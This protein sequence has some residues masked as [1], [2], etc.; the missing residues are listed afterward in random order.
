MSIIQNRIVIMFII[1]AIGFICAKTGL[2]DG[3]GNKKLSKLT[4]WLVNPLLMFMSYQSEYSS[5]VAKNLLLTLLCSAAVFALHI[6]AASLLIPRKNKE[7]AIERM[8]V[9]FSNCGFIGIP[10]VQGVY[11]SEGVIYVTM[12][13]TVFNILIWTYGVFMMKGSRPDSLKGCLKNL[14]T[15]AIISVISGLVFYFCRISLPHIISEPLNAVGSMNTPMAMLVAGATL[16][17]TNFAKCL[18]K[19]RIYLLCAVKLLIFPLLGVA[20]IFWTAALGVPPLVISVVAI[21]VSCP[22]AATTTMLSHTYGRDSL[23]ASEIFA[24][25]TL[26]SALTLP[27]VMKAADMLIKMLV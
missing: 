7:Y 26:F 9:I 10:L 24:L 21:A 16:A 15:P 1:M 19:P 20:A 27:A 25:T 23:W 4:L 12:F 13:N 6:A 11:G 5:T 17:G 18:K 14:C 22:S 8:S 2:I 3:E